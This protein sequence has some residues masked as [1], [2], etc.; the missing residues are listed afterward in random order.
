MDPLSPVGAVQGWDSGFIPDIMQWSC[1]K[2]CIAIPFLSS[3]CFTVCLCS[4]IRYF[5]CPACLTDVYLGTVLTRNFVHNSFLLFSFSPGLHLHQFV[6]HCSEQW[7]FYGGGAP[8]HLLWPTPWYYAWIRLMSAIKVLDDARKGPG[9][10]V[11]IEVEVPISVCSP[12]SVLRQL[13][14]SAISSP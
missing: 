2:M 12:F 3:N 14:C 8:L 6:S 4:E 11:G 1:L 5:Q 13:A 7:R 9:V 10:V